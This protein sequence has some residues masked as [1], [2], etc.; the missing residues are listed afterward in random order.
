[1]INEKLSISNDKVI[2]LNECIHLDRDKIDLL[3]ANTSVIP[4]IQIEL[5]HLHQVSSSD[6]LKINKCESSIH[7]LRGNKCDLTL[8]KEL[9][10][11]LTNLLSQYNL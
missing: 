3:I 11:K 10:L 6:N 1:M 7:L 8:F 2:E 9:E 5:L 4:K